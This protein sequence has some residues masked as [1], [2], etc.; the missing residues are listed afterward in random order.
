MKLE[1]LETKLN[2]IRSRIKWRQFAIDNYTAKMIDGSLNNQLML[3]AELSVKRLKSEIKQL[4]KENNYF[5][6]ICEHMLLQ[7]RY[8]PL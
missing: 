2:P 7:Y 4:E 5:Q 1:E 6:Q 8:W 3:I